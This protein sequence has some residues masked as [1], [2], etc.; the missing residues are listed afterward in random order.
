M[1]Y[2]FHKK[3]FI[4][5]LLIKLFLIYQI[6]CESQNCDN[7]RVNDDKSCISS[8]S[9]PDLC[10]SNCRTSFII[11]TG[12]HYCDFAPLQQ[13]Y[14]ITT[15]ECIVKRFCGIDEKLID[16]TKECVESCNYGYYELGDYCYTESGKPQ[17]SEIIDY[18]LKCQYNYYINSTEGLKK[19]TCLQSGINCPPEFPSYYLNDKLCFQGDCEALEISDIRTKIIEEGNSYECFT[20]CNNEDYLKINGHS[21]YC[22]ESCDPPQLKMLD[23]IEN[24]CID[25]NECKEKGKYIKDEEFCVDEIICDFYYN[26]ICIEESCSS[27]DKYNNYN[28]KVCVDSCIEPYK[29]KDE[30]NKICYQICPSNFISEDEIYCIPEPAND[31]FFIGNGNNKKCYLSCPNEYYHVNENKECLLQCPEEGN[32]YYKYKNFI[33]YDS[34][35]TIFGNDNYFFSEK[36]N[37]SIEC[38]EDE[39]KC[40]EAGYKY[41]ANSNKCVNECLETQFKVDFTLNSLGKIDTLGKCFNTKDECKENSY[42]FYNSQMKKCWKYS[43]PEGMKTNENDSSGEPKEFL[44]NT[45]AQSCPIELPILSGNFCK[46]ACP[47]DKYYDPDNEDNECVSN[48]GEKKI[49]PNNKCMINCPNHYFYINNNGKM[50]CTDSNECPIQYFKFNNDYQCYSQCSKILDGKIKHFFYNSQKDCLE[51]CKD[52]TEDDKKYGYEPKDGPQECEVLP[53]DKYYYDINNILLD[54]CILY[55][56]PTS[57]KCVTQCLDGQKIDIIDGKKICVDTCPNGKQYY[58]ETS[59]E[60][61]GQ[62]SQ[63]YICVGN[64]KDVSSEYAFILRNSKKCMKDCS[65]D[66]YYKVGDFCYLKCD[67]DGIKYLNAENN[68]ECQ[69]SCDKIYYQELSSSIQNVYI[70][71]NNCEKPY[72]KVEETGIKECLLECPLGFNYI[73]NENECKR[74]DSTIEKYIIETKKESYNIYKY[75]ESCPDHRYYSKYEHLCFETCLDSNYKFLLD[76]TCSNSCIKDDG[77]NLYYTENEKICMAGCD[78]NSLYKYHIENDYLCI[79]DCP[80]PYHLEGTK[81][82]LICGN[83]KPYL[84]DNNECVEKCPLGKQFYI[85]GFTHGESDIQKRCLTDC[86]EF[87]PYYI[88]KEMSGGIINYECK[89]ECSG[90]SLINIDERIIGKKCLIGEN[91]CP[92]IAPNIYPYEYNRKNK[93]ECY[94]VCPRGLFYIEYT[95]A[96]ASDYQYSKKCLETCPDEFYFHEKDLYICKKP[97]ECISQFADYDS[98]TCVENC[99]TPYVSEIYQGGSLI[100]TICLNS[101]SQKYGR[102]LT[103]DNKCVT[104]CS[105]IPDGYL[106]NDNS[107][108]CKCQNLFYYD[109]LNIMRCIDPTKDNCKDTTGNY[110]IR[111]TETKECLKICNGI[112]SLNEDECYE[113]TFD[114]SQNDIKTK[115]SILSNGQKKCECKFKYHYDNGN[116][117]C[118]TEE[119][120]C[121]PHYLYIPETN[122]CVTSCTSPFI[123]KFDNFCLRRCPDKSSEETVNVCSCDKYWYSLSNQNFICL[124]VNICP[125]SHPLI[126]LNTKQCL[127]ECRGNANEI[128]L[129]DKCLSS[130]EAYETKTLIPSFAKE[131][132][133][134]NYYCLCNNEWYYDISTKSNRCSNTPTTCSSFYPNSKYTV[135]ETK[136]C[137]IS[138]PEEY[139]YIFNS[140]CVHS[141]ENHRI[142]YNIKSVQNSKVCE[143]INLWEYDINNDFIC[144]STDYCPNTPIEYVEIVETKQCLKGN[145]CPSNYPL[146][147]N[148][149]CY[150]KNN[151]PENSYYN[152][153]IE[154]TCVCQNLW[155]KYTDPNINLPFIFCLP[156]N[157]ERCPMHSYT[158]YPYQISRTKECL[159]EGIKCPENSYVFNYICYESGCPT[160]TTEDI[161]NYDNANKIHYCICDTTLGYWYVYPD[162]NYR[163][164][165][166]CALEKCEG[167]YFNLYIK[168]N[169]CIRSCNIKTGETSHQPMVSFR[170]TCYEECPDFTKPK[171]DFIYECGFYKLNEAN[172]LEQL[173]DYVNIQV[174]ELYNIANIGGY[175]FNN[176]ETSVQIYGTNKENNIN[177]KNLI[178]KSNLA[179][180]DLGTCTEKIYEDNKLSDDDKILIIKYDM[181]S[182][183]INSIDS[184][185]SNTDIIN[186]DDIN[187]YYLINPV[188][189]EFFSSV[190]GEKIDASICEPNEI[191]VSYPISYTI[192]KYDE[193][194]N[195]MNTNEY[196]KKFDLGKQINHKNNKLDTFN[197]N[198][199][200]YQD[201]CTGI[202]INGKD[203]VLEDRFENLYPNN[204]T[205][206]ENNCTY[207]YTDFELGRI[208]CKCNY[209]K[210]LDF[211]RKY[212]ESSDLLNDPD[213][214]HPTQSGS[215]VQIIKC[216]SK[217]PGKDSILKNEAFFYSA[218]I[219]VAE[220]SMIFV[221]A[222]H[223]IKAVSANITSLLNKPNIKMDIGNKNR[224]KRNKYKNDNNI[225]TSHRVLSSPPKK[226]DNNLTE[227][228]EEEQKSEYIGNIINKKNIE[229]INQKTNNMVINNDIE[230]DGINESENNNYGLDIKN[231]GISSNVKNNNNNLI[232]NQ[233]KYADIDFTG[234]TEFM[235]MNYNFKYFKSNDKGTIKK[236]E[237]NKLQF[238]VKPS[239]KYILERKENINYEPDYLNGPFLPTQNIIEIIDDEK[240]IKYE[241]DQNQALDKKIDKNE[242]NKNGN[243]NNNI[244]NKNSL[245]E[246]KNTKLRNLKNNKDLNTE[247]DFI[248]IKKIGPSRRKNDTTF[249]VQDYKEPKE[250][251]DIYD[252]TGLYTL[253]KREQALLRVP[254]KKYLEKNHPNLLSIFL[255]EIMDKIYLIKICCFLKKFE[256]FSVH[257]TLYLICHL[258]LLTLLCAFFT[259]KTIKKIW[260]QSN[261]PQLNFYLLYGFLGNIVI[262]VIYKIFL[263]LLDSQDKVKELINLKNKE[264][265]ENNNKENNN[266][267]DDISEGGDGVDE[268]L[269]K[270]KFNNVIKRIKIRMII[271]FIIGFLI[272]IFCFIYLVSFFAIYT[273]TKSKVF[274]M[275]YIALIEILLIKII[276]GIILASL[277]IASEGNEIK[278]IYKVVYICDKYVS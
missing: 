162:E 191:M 277:R 152:S 95:N 5:F 103:P 98:K 113:N 231:G 82:V 80:N 79:K 240:V 151:C 186:N 209:K 172:S 241:N 81:C 226:G 220:I 111:K 37:G 222:F 245:I 86:T 131:Y 150:K 260:T 58:Y 190:T 94:S 215:N 142:E 18:K 41:I 174:R 154:G 249:I 214:N 52:N 16:N 257:L 196:K 61:L 109:D 76:D 265:N 132:K 101:C 32:K 130:C 11:S 26:N 168:G 202:E 205:L 155:Y 118:L 148:K 218:V 199:T 100:A 83:D 57:Q 1:K 255:A 34:C 85:E 13:Y 236:I 124:D 140:E 276:Y 208:N 263:C 134:A 117:I 177:D 120:D 84:N 7:C 20:K 229:I 45:C 35:R 14:S 10:P 39:T 56:S 250:E 269:I 211:Y 143:C 78:Q 70:C 122:G 69:P 91:I 107:Y 93:K 48:C 67:G 36:D 234:K 212:P 108:V 242:T 27:I 31:C 239:T 3:N 77:T 15:N 238:K 2:M 47:P 254:F 116:K 22:V 273:G 198:N 223:G 207:Y 268:E 256:M 112:L 49:G 203:L 270:Q 210:E 145:A 247:K 133:L 167:Y 267:I 137:V 74:K 28:T 160:N 204:V 44:G 271:F 158:K 64:C 197:F 237:R 189:Y 235:P 72:F 123:K 136:E 106:I 19:Y 153:S 161:D 225:T 127:K 9:D 62:F 87:Y 200:V 213:F 192:K 221:A 184:D 115:L 89:G 169:E 163:D 63:I 53:H 54:N 182:I 266:N 259:I 252:N 159:A 166:Q 141:C 178:M 104:D 206:C 149:K 65:E 119:E 246:T 50:Q 126:N 21:K 188:E 46:L 55:E 217:L 12:C 105:A 75:I 251:R 278:T 216:L 243:E 71:S 8:T 193:F 38:Y 92:L 180:I 232:D 135:K 144:L 171:V 195:G 128:L 164:Y 228:N 201:I 165:Y 66:Y 17:Y 42:K 43:C 258:M 181:S 227:D 185:G 262:F 173:R 272:T 219:T 23:S 125:K 88:E 233:N 25:F 97:Q 121:P 138:C 183:N 224:A 6:Y 147:F 4:G 114:C 146:L 176:S 261:F 253:I 68:F 170:G 157:I 99:N 129:I 274:K 248:T 59:I 264:N 179:Y 110:K 275:Y 60:I 33:C 175:L 139:P 102:Y 29:Y 96:E 24:I 40:I 194:I 90:I 244:N 73:Q 156:K 30:I 230:S 51:S 187:N